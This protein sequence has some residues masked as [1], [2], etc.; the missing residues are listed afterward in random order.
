MLQK[1]DEAT[2][3]ITHNL[4]W[5]AY[6][7]PQPELAGQQKK[8]LLVA[9]IVMGIYDVPYTSKTHKRLTRMLSN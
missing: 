3:T 8:S 7:H 5:L 4:N 6:D 9:I 2:H 1:S